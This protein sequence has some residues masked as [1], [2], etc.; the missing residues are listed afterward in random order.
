MRRGGALLCAAT[1]SSSSMMVLAVL[2]LSL[3]CLLHCS[4]IMTYGFVIDTTG[5][6]SSSTSTSIMRPSFRSL[7]SDRISSGASMLLLASGDAN[8]EPDLFDY[9]DPLLSPHA[10]P[11]GVSPK[12][13]PN[14]RP[15]TYTR[16]SSSTSTGGNSFGFDLGLNGNNDVDVDDAASPSSTSSSKSNIDTS[17]TKSPNGEKE[18]DLFDYFDPLLSPH[19]YPDGIKS[20]TS[21]S[22]SSQSTDDDDND[23]DRYNPLRFKTLP[24]VGFSSSSESTTTPKPKETSNND[25]K[26]KR[27]NTNTLGVLLI[28]HGSRND[29]SN[30]RLEK[31]AQLYQLSM[32]FHE[33]EDEDG[34]DTSTTSATKVLV[35]AAHMEIAKPSIE[36]GLRELINQNVGTFLSRAHVTS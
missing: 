6:S 23:D 28:D 12:N 14:E 20:S 2:V 36:D 19:A 5:A 13:Q 7:Y 16:G 9:F 17:D 27:K 35:Q 22:S 4:T 15:E 26:E 8:E 34:K 1:S 11:D 18:E 32:E 31:L 33:H 3:Q 25:G 30:V 29:A 21:S 10:Y 24:V